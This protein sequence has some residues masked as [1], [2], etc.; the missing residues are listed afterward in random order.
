MTAGVSRDAPAN[1]KG[2]HMT[3]KLTDNTGNSVIIEA[4]TPKKAYR[5]AAATMLHAPVKIELVEEVD[6]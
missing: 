5:M 1:Q 2:Q 6:K 3:Y 4:P